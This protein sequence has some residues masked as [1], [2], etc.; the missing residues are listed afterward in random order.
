[1]EGQ[2]SADPVLSIFRLATGVLHDVI[3][4][5]IYSSLVLRYNAYSKLLLQVSLLSHITR[6]ST[7]Y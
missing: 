1:M 2:Q 7:V 3:R 4:K 6:V 5:H